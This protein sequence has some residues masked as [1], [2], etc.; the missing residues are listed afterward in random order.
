MI[1]DALPFLVGALAILI[2]FIAPIF[3]RWSERRELARVWGPDLGR[4]MTERHEGDGPTILTRE[5]TIVYI[6]LWPASVLIS[7]TTP[8]DLAR[9]FG[10]QS[11]ILAMVVKRHAGV[12]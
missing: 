10:V 8:E 3:F 6:D 9:G 12:I 7:R 2:V 11:D 4:M 5:L 1:Q